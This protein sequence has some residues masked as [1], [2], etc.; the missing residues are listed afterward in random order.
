MLTAESELDN[1][2]LGFRARAILRGDVYLLGDADRRGRPRAEVGAD[3]VSEGW[4]LG[5]DVL[6]ESAG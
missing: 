3:N 5:I 2:A 6:N 1:L 4:M